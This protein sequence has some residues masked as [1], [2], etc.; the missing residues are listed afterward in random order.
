[1]AKLGRHEVN[2]RIGF[3]EEKTLERF[4]HRENLGGRPGW[5][6]SQRVLGRRL[7][8]SPGHIRHLKG[9]T[10]NP[11]QGLQSRI[12]RIYNYEKRLEEMEDGRKF[13]RKQRSGADG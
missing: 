7:H 6:E 10:R 13:G 1:M 5:R 2:L 3:L 12:N 9:Y 8:I 4:L 11:S